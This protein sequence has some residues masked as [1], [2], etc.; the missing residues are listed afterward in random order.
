MDFARLL[1]QERFEDLCKQILRLEFGDNV[2]GVDGRGGDEGTDSF[3]GTILQQTVIFQ[4]K[5]FPAQFNNSRRTKI[6][7]SLKNSYAKNPNEWYL[8]VP[9]N[10][11]IYDW[12]WWESLKDEYKNVKLT[13]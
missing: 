12:K 4:F 6:I 11:T 10:L 8:L 5:F 1:Y 13:I 9:A 3:I 2:F 7:K